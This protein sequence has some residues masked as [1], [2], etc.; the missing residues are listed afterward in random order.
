MKFEVL[1]ADG[2]A[3]GSC[4]S[5]TTVTSHGETPT[6]KL[7]GYESSNGGLDADFWKGRAAFWREMWQTESVSRFDH[8]NFYRDGYIRRGKAIAELTEQFREK[9]E[10]IHAFYAPQLVNRKAEQEEFEQLKRIADNEKDSASYWFSEAGRRLTRLNE[11]EQR[12]AVLEAENERLQETVR[13]REASIPAPSV[14]S[15]SE[16]HE[17]QIGA[18]IRERD[19]HAAAFRSA[20]RRSVASSHENERLREENERLVDA[21]NRVADVVNETAGES[22]D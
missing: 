4:E 5:V 12:V 18:L 21:L 9:K 10:R 6:V 17:E 1:G 20:H 22:D 19:K 7:E 11:A 15:L 3:I 2:Q 13:M 8:V 14:E 16:E